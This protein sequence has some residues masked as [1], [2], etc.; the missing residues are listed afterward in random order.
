MSFE[1]GKYHVDKDTYEWCLRQSKRLKA[2]EPQMN[3]Q[4]MNQKILTQMPGELKHSVKFRCNFNCTLDD[5]ANTVQDIRKRKNIG[6]YSPYKSSCFKEKQPFRV[7]FKDKT[8]ERVAEVAKK[9]NSFHNCGSTDHYFN[10]CPK[11]KKKV[12]AIDKVP[13]EESPTEDSESDSMCQPVT[14]NRVPA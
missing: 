10:K 3:I 13:E 4:M 11:A 5:V 9:K 14:Q 8:R 2:I 1:N 7:D 6:K 12:Y